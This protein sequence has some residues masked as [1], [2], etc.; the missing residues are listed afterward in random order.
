[1][2][3]WEADTI[4]RGL[5]SESPGYI[6]DN[7]DGRTGSMKKGK[8]QTKEKETRRKYSSIAPGSPIT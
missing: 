8:S 4:A 3:M 1:M 7:K 5:T 2:L 6:A